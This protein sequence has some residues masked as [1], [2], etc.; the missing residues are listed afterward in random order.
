[1]G[2]E[3][4]SVENKDLKKSEEKPKMVEMET[5][6]SN[7]MAVTVK[8]EEGRV[9]KFVMPFY[10]PLDECYHATINVANEIARLFNETVEKAKKAALEKE[11]TSLEEK[12]K[13]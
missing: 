4:T 7:D 1:M 13:P 2:K 5:V 8:G 6:T 12:A 3:N 9:Y 11:K 10:S